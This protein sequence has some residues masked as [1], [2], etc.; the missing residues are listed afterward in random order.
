MPRTKR[1]TSE[2]QEEYYCR[3]CMRDRVS[4]FF[5]SATNPMLD[6]N[7]YMSIC[8]DCV[9]DMYDNF[10]QTELSMEAT[11]LRLCR[12]LDVKYDED[13]IGSTK[14]QME[15]YEAKGS[16]MKNIFGVYKSKLSTANRFVK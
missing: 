1:K 2:V 11:I 9:N 15:T 5:Y 16:S 14:I 4:R 12:L 8:K 6:T 13:A 3:K 10:I 7:G